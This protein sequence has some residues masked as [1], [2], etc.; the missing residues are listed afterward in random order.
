MEKDNKETIFQIISA[1]AT[2]LALYTK[3]KYIVIISFITIMTSVFFWYGENIITPLSFLQ[4]E[5]RELR[6]D[7]NMRKEIEE[8]K[9]Q[10]SIINMRITQTKKGGL[11]PIWFIIIIG[12]IIIVMLYLQ[13]KGFI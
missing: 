6:K 1:I 9:Q 11:D 3:D 12:A 10:M 2:V 5:T 8:V 13:D 4:Q 7:L